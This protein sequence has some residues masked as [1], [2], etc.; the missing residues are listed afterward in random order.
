MTRGG[1]LP[2]TGA[3]YI[4]QA[5]YVD[6]WRDLIRQG[7]NQPDPAAAERRRRIQALLDEEELE[8]KAEEEAQQPPARRQRRVEGTGVAIRSRHKSKH[9]EGR[10]LFKKLWHETS[11][12][13]VIEPAL[14]HTVAEPQSLKSP[15]K[16][17][18]ATNDRELS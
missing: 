3:A 7:M 12:P 16:D 10:G 8:E 13:S 9:G 17:L 2:Q 15:V 14:K 4:P 6:P 1:A 11:R 5:V 18:S